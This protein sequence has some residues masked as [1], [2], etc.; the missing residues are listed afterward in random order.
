MIPRQEIALVRLTEVGMVV[1]VG[2]YIQLRLV[3]QLLGWRPQDAGRAALSPSL[4]LNTAQYW[5]LTITPSHHHISHHLTTS[6]S[7]HITISPSHHITI[8]FHTVNL[9]IFI[10]QRVNELGT[11]KLLKSFPEKYPIYI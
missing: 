10:K 5:D 7:Q 8:T 9:D 1:V 6:P 4:T 3:T 11:N 2:V